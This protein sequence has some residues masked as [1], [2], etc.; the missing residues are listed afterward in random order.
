[1]AG[2]DTAEQRVGFGTRQRL[3]FQQLEIAV[4]P[5][6]PDRI[7]NWFTSADGHDDKRRAAHHQL[8]QHERRQRIQEV[9]IVDSDHGTRAA[10]SCRQRV[11]DG[12]AQLQSVGLMIGHPLRER[13]Q[14]NRLGALGSH[15]PAHSHTT[16]GGDGHRFAGQPALPDSRRTDDRHAAGCAPFTDPVGDQ[17]EFFVAAGQGPHSGHRCCPHT[18]LLGKDRRGPRGS[19]PPGGP[20]VAVSGGGKL[21]LRQ[22]HEGVHG[23]AFHPHP[24]GDH[25]V[26]HSG[27]AQPQRRRIRQRQLIQGFIAPASVGSHHARM[28]AAVALRWGTPLPHRQGSE[29]MTCVNARAATRPWTSKMK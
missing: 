1:M 20:L 17:A 27:V 28:P 9:R 11:D 10:R 21:G 3:Q 23:R 6:R 7:G 14:W 22:P 26:G 25:L 29:P 4:L 19:L 18:D 15:G 5:Q 2:K 16:S 13:T 8:V 12:A 24:F